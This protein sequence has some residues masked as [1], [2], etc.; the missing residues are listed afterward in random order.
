MPSSE[1]K[2]ACVT[3][4]LDRCL[5]ATHQDTALKP[6]RP[7]CMPILQMRESGWLPGAMEMFTGPS[8]KRDMCRIRT[9]SFGGE[10]CPKPQR[11]QT[12]LRVGP[13]NEGAAEG[14]G[15]L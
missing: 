14:T 3:K 15:F 13:P 5:S 1:H 2:V 8:G 4:R 6:P 11:L 10:L 9:Q 7:P 12:G